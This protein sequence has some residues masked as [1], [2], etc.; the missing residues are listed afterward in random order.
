MHFFIFTKTCITQRSHLPL[1]PCRKTHKTNTHHWQIGKPICSKNACQLNLN[2]EH[3]HIFGNKCP[4]EKCEKKKKCQTQPSWNSNSEKDG[5]L[6]TRL[7]SLD[8]EEG[9]LLEDAIEAGLMGAS[10]LSRRVLSRPFSL[11]ECAGLPRGEEG[12]YKV[13]SQVLM[14]HRTFIMLEYLGVDVSNCKYLIV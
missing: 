8:L 11:G 7:S 13:T 6:L 9:V 1:S 5:E 10:F 12:S 2:A 14:Q 4:I 3:I